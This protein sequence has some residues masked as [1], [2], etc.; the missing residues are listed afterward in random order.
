MLG[1]TNPLVR[2]HDVEGRS[3]AANHARDVIQH[4]IRFLLF[5]KELDIGVK[6]VTLR[7]VNLLAH[8]L[9]PRNLNLGES[10]PARSTRRNPPGG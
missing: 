7:D 2:S 8:N 1:L 4:A 9:C 5:P 3:R 6:E 10:V